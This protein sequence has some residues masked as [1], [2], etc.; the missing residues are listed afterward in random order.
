MTADRNPIGGP[1]RVPLGA[2]ARDIGE[3][4]NDALRLAQVL[5][6]V[7]GD[8]DPVPVALDVGRSARPLFPV[9]FPLAP[10]AVLALEP[11]DLRAQGLPIAGHRWDYAPAPWSLKY[12]R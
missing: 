8:R 5:V 10:H 3:V 4:V 7:D 9:L 1:V 12:A 11:P 2:E 6:E